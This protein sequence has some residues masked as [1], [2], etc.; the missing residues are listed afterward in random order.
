MA[1]TDWV[2][3]LF[4]APQRPVVPPP[5]PPAFVPPRPSLT[6]PP[7]APKHRLP[8]IE[9]LEATGPLTCEET[10]SLGLQLARSVALEPGPRR[11]RGVTARTLFFSPDGVVSA[12]NPSARFEFM[13]PEEARG[14]GT[15]ERTDVYVV[16]LFLYS[17]LLGERALGVAD[18]DLETLRRAV[19][20]EL[21]PL[22]LSVTAALGAV[23]RRCVEREPD[24]RFASLAALANALEPLPRDDERLRCRIEQA[25]HALKIAPHPSAEPTAEELLVRA[26]TGD[27]AARLVYADL[28]ESEGLTSE[29]QWLRL[30]VCLRGERG[31][32][33][34]ATLTAM[35]ALEV[36]LAFVTSVSR[37]E[38]ETCAVQFGFRC[39]RTWDALKLT[40]D[41]LTRFCDACRERVHFATD[42]ET[43]ERLAAEG[44]CVAVADHVARTGEPLGQREVRSGYVGQGVA[45]RNPGRKR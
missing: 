9:L 27:D 37:A 10:A 39:P 2:R 43:A 25:C 44:H 6:R 38:L 7:R 32:A 45:L 40:A 5:A 24:R 22:R 31:A 11:L 42:L 8:F 20:V 28:L 29:A 14:L 19:E 12:A 35:R 34:L 18:S 13:P 30:E 23:V 4:E 3:S 41:P 15:D 21:L 1:F 26:R 17:A 36:S 33:Q 16:G